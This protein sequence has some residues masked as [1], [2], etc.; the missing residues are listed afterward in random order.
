MRLRTLV[1]LLVILGI[2]SGV[3][4]WVFWQRAPK[5]RQELGRPLMGALP[6]AEI[7]AIDVIDSAGRVS[8]RQEAEQWVVE[9]RFRY[10]ADFGRIRDLVRRLKDAKIGRQFEAT[11]EVRARLSLKD[12][13]D[14]TAAAG[15][16]GI[17]LRFMGDQGKILDGLILGKTR[18]SAAEDGL[19]AGQYVMRAEGPVVYL[20]DQHFMG[21]KAD[22]VLW[23]NK[24]LLQVPAGDIQKITAVNGR[25]NPEFVLW[26]AE[27]GKELELRFPAA[28]PRPLNRASVNRLAG[29][30]ASLRLEDVAGQ[31]SASG[32]MGVEDGPYLVFYTFEGTL[33]RVYPQSACEQ[34]CHLRL[35]VDY[36]APDTQAA[37]ASGEAEATSSSSAPEATPGQQ[38]LALEAER[39]NASLSPWVFRIPQ[40]QHEA[41]ATHLE[42]LLEKET[43]A[44]GKP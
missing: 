33:Y 7:T 25:G 30:L 26:R 16:T 13:T 34:D 4:S 35:E 28:S 24:T 32:P 37:P 41:L 31:E 15:E 29:A 20:I 1:I 3:G 22:P 44:A 14:E 42:G 40:W 36:Q 11:A 19:V 21:T 9:E 2:L 39:L 38:A 43:P 12:P 5:A 6:A 17:L 18:K 8:L 27:R 23:L 10:P